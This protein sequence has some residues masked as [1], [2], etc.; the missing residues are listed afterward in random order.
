MKLHYLVKLNTT[1][2]FIPFTS[3]RLPDT[4]NVHQV[5]WAHDVFQYTNILWLPSM[6]KS[7][8]CWACLICCFKR[9]RLPADLWSKSTRCRKI[10]P[11]SIWSVPCFWKA[12]EM[13]S[14]W[15]R[16]VNSGIWWIDLS[17][18]ICSRVLRGGPASSLDW[19]VLGLW[20][21]S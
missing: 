21:L 8:G 15:C 3:L 12:S 10:S 14:L 5:T 6:S 2:H 18:S 17:D 19:S 4:V 20:L 1:R 16:T 7:N 9:R 11:V 13:L